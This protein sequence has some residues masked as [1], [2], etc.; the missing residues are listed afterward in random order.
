MVG[1]LNLKK[2]E[3]ILKKEKTKYWSATHKYGL[4]LPKS[5]AQ[6][7]AIDKRTGTDFW[8]KAI[9]NEIRNVF[10]A[11]EFLESNDD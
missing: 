4:E 9:E 2:R 7:L 11:F 1:I 5:V 3:R 10:S 6:A 8:K